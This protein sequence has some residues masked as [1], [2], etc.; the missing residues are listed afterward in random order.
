MARKRICLDCRKLRPEA[1]MVRGRCPECRR[2]QDRGSFYQSPEWDQLRKLALRL[3]KPRECTVCGSTWRLTLH[4]LVPRE[5]DGADKLENLCWLCGNCHSGYEGDKR[6]GRTTDLTRVVDA[7]ASAPAP[8]FL[9]GPSFGIAPSH[10]RENLG[11]VRFLVGALHIRAR[12]QQAFRFVPNL[13][14]GCH[15]A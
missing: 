4:H 6:A 7:L 12:A 5:M 13:Y 1:A 15:A 9:R 10:A 3:L 8:R 11:F 14:R 2:E